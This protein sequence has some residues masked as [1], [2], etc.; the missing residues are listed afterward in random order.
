[1]SFNFNI[2]KS[3]SVVMKK[4]LVFALFLLALAVA[5]GQTASNGYLQAMRKHLAGLDSVYIASE[6][7]ARANAFEHMADAEP[8]QWLP[9][10]Y[11]ALC[12]I[13]AF[14]FEEDRSQQKRYCDQ[15]DRFIARAEALQPNES[16]IALLRSMAASMRIRLSPMLNGARYG[17]IADQMLDRAQRL[18]PD[19]PRVYVQRATNLYFTPSIWGG[20]KQKAREM[21]DK[22]EQKFKVFK[23]ASDIHPDWGRSTVQYLRSLMERE[24]G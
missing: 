9:A 7:V 15:A 6:W 5:Q 22:A 24:K 20:D 12:Y 2:F 11:A 18:N 17:H 23:P 10:Y 13:Q 1:M 3:F 4:P 19:N 8:Q 16:E 14:N 21:V